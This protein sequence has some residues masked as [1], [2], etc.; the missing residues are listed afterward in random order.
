[1]GEVASDYN[2]E[3]NELHNILNLSITVPNM[4]HQMLEF[5]RKRQ[6]QSKNKYERIQYPFTVS[7]LPCIAM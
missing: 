2:E 3:I 4:S 6:L 1:M 7:M 5:R